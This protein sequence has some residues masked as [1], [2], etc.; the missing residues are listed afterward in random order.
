M[1]GKTGVNHPMGKNMI[2]AFHQ[3]SAV[4]A[5]VDTLATLPDRQLS[6]GLAEVVKYG[7]IRDPEFFEWVEENAVGLLAREPE[8]MIYAVRRSCE[9]KAAVV[10]QD[11]RES[12]VRALLNL[13]HTFG[14]AIETAL[15]YE[16][17]LH[18]E[19][20]AAGTVMAADLS[21]RMGW[22]D[23]SCVARIRELLTR[24][25]LPVEPPPG[26]GAE[27]FESLMGRDKKVLAGKLRLVLLREI[28]DA[29]LCDDFPEKDFRATLGA[30]AG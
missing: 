20:V 30:Y 29:V 13:G 12:G 22:I 23:S 4:L 28:G 24:L 8:L 11:E 16:D 26:I 14:H 10:A 9:N 5:D 19:A 21:S 25:R 17:W 18:G 7:L 15:N 6:A 1:G 2:G 3:P 27:R